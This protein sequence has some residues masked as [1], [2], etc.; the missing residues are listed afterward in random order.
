M[1]TYSTRVVHN[2][3]IKICLIVPTLE[4]SRPRIIYSTKV[5]KRQSQHVYGRNFIVFSGLCQVCYLQRS[6]LE[7][8]TLI[9]HRL[10]LT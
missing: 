5:F 9:I 8:V 1:T 10:A 3:V 4:L 6:C 7:A 2:K